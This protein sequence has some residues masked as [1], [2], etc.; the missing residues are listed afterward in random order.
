MRH[1]FFIC[2]LTALTLFLSVS[3]LHAS[4][5]EASY[6]KIYIE[7]KPY[8]VYTVKPGEGLYAVART[9]SVSVDDL[10]KAN[11]G[12]ENGLKVGQTLNV[13]VKKESALSPKHSSS[14]VT[15]KPQNPVKQTKNDDSQKTSFKHIVARG[16]TVYSLANMYDTTEEAIYQLNPSAKEGIY[17]GDTLL[18]PQRQTAGSNEE[19]KYRYHTILPKETLYS[20]SRSFNLSPED[21]IAANPGLSAETFQAGKTIRIPFE[22]AS[23]PAMQNQYI[24]K[25]TIHRVEKGETLYSIARKYNALQEDI[26]KA[27]PD[28]PEKLKPNTYLTIPIRVSVQ[29]QTDSKAEEAKANRLFQQSR[30]SDKLQV[31]RVGLLLPFLD[32][33]NNGHLRLQEYYEGMLLAVMKLKNQGANIEF[34]SFD[35]GKGNDTG[36]LQSLLGT[37]EMQS[38]D[39]IIGGISDFQIKTISDFSRKNNIKY[40]VP[41]S[42]SNREV[43]NNARIFQVNPPLSS[44]YSSASDVF[45][46]TFRGSNIIFVKVPDKSD[47]SDFVNTLQNDLKKA[48]MTSNSVT[49][50]EA[51]DQNLQSALVANRENVIVPTSGDMASLR[52]LIDGMKKIQSDNK[53]YVIRLF[54]YPEWQTYDEKFK[55]DFHQFGTYIFTPF[56]VDENDP[57][58]KEFN[59]L[60]HQWYK[61]DLLN[62]YPRYGMWGYDTGMFFL[63]ALYKYGRNFE[64]NISS[65]NNLN[66]LQYAYHFERVNNWGGFIND[67]LYLV[68]YDPN[69]VVIKVNKSR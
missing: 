7:G 44:T 52:T 31:I 9:F 11:P 58:T 10:L 8:Y 43:M 39:L 5:Q 62:L 12:C 53:G 34:Y 28:L 63:T 65:L 67:G 33:T 54:G 18:I 42:Q 22:S 35:I 29:E 38:L 6:T 25:K 68:Y 46:E 15:S 4:A 61:R 23:K 17:V 69:Q 60:F 3:L 30:P 59:A 32:E 21:I 47:K 19:D 37:M 56:F 14:K 2:K 26:L 48:K 1:T 41:F 20:V 57:D 24:I 55:T 66:T 27:N 45:V 36:K 13:P 49:L 40:V 16:E 64:Q 50:D 51:I